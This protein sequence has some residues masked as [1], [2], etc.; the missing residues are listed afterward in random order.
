[1][2]E[3]LRIE[4][5]VASAEGTPGPKDPRLF[6]RL[7]AAAHL[8]RLLDDAGKGDGKAPD[9]ALAEGL[10]RKL[11]ELSLFSGP[12]VVAILSWEDLAADLVLV[13]K[14]GD[15][16]AALPELAE[17]SSV[18]LSALEGA[19]GDE[20]RL[21]FAVRARNAAPGRDVAVTLHVITWDGKSFRVKIVKAKL[22][23]STKEAAL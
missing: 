14:E 5:Q 1:V 19:I 20:A 22:A 7:G 3:A 6:A 12:S 23:A 4:R 11:K 8:A 10:S 13:A 16:D 17:S 18:G 15:K 2:D 9:A 21:A